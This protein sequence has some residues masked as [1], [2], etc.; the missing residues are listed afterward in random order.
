MKFS[1]DKTQKVLKKK[2]STQL[3][4][5]ISFQR[6]NTMSNLPMI[7]NNDINELTTTIYHRN[8]KNI[9]RIECSTSD[10]TES[11][12]EI[13]LEIVEYLCVHRHNMPI[14]IN[15]EIIHLSRYQNQSYLIFQ[16]IF[17]I[18]N[19]SQ[20]NESIISFFISFNL[21]F[22][23]IFDYYSKQNTNVVVIIIFVDFSALKISLPVGFEYHVALMIVLF[24]L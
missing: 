4:D 17:Y 20:T 16:T 2:K 3:I 7:D 13:K 15:I 6:A 24:I 21:M 23:N 8:K 18:G 19:I 9:I 14:I 5:F 10:Y 22:E 1:K 12:A 11:K